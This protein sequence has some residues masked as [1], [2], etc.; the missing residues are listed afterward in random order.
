[1]TARQIYWIGKNIV[2]YFT[3]QLPFK[4]EKDSFLFIRQDVAIIDFHFNHLSQVS[5]ELCL[6]SSH[7]KS[8]VCTRY[9]KDFAF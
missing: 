4:R 9:R 3:F 2:T 5:N 1:M 7:S 8:K 6:S